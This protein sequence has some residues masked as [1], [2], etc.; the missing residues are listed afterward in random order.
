MAGETLLSIAEMLASAEDNTQGLITPLDLRNIIVSNASDIGYL[1]LTQ[2]NPVT[3][4]ID[5][6]VWT[7]INPL[8]TPSTTAGNAWKLDANQA[9]SYSYVDDGIAVNPGTL[10]LAVFTV[11]MTAAKIGQGEEQYE[12]ALFA[13]GVQ[14]GNSLGFTLF[15]DPETFAVAG[16]AARVLDVSTPAVYD[17]R[18]TSDQPDDVILTSFT[19]RVNGAAL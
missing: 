10:R 15:T 17:A 11:E 8:I 12:L 1:S 16:S 13:D 2:G 3:V 6:G 4:P 14:E 9:F 7:S 19:M 18:I 5:T